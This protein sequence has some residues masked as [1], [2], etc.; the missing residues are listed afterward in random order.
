MLERRWPWGQ[1]FDILRPYVSPFRLLRKLKFACPA[2]SRTSETLP[3]GS[4]IC[5]CRRLDLDVQTLING[6]L[7]YEPDLAGGLPATNRNAVRASHARADLNARRRR[8]PDGR[9]C[10]CRAGN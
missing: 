1:V 9:K 4:A 8:I 7:D 2:S 10:G 6:C 5:T 3:E